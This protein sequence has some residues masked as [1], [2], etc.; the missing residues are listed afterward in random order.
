MRLGKSGAAVLFVL[1]VFPRTGDGDQTG[2]V[3]GRVRNGTMD[4]AA[5]QNEGVI[6]YQAVN[7]KKQEDFL[8]NTWTDDSGYFHFEGLP[9]GEG[10]AYYPVAVHGGVEY[11]GTWVEFPSTAAGTQKRSD[12]LVYEATSSDS[13]VSVPVHHIIVEPEPGALGVREVFFFVNEGSRTYVGG[14]EYSPGKNIVL[15]MELPVQ[16]KELVLDGDIMTC[17]IITDRNRVIDTM[18]LKPGSRQVIANYRVPHTGPTVRFSKAVSYSTGGLDLFIVGSEITNIDIREPGESP[19]RAVSGDVETS[20]PFRIRGRE[21][22][23][24]SLGQI[25]RGSE[26]TVTFAG[27]APFS[28]AYRWVAPAVLV[29]IMIALTG[30]HRIRLR[31]EDSD[32]PDRK[33]ES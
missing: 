12:I 22:K 1:S 8:Q 28:R 32:P 27:L 14:R 29:L 16:A 23:R 33:R 20:R 10:V 18:E 15:E 30:Y 17:C 11:A 2:T 24:Y 3:S 5:V 6:L 13:A 25:A 26:V 9:M 19:A 21:Y 7:G 4:S 31:R